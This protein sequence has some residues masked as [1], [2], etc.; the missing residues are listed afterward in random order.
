MSCVMD[1]LKIVF[2]ALIGLQALTT[3]AGENPP[4]ATPLGTGDIVES[5]NGKAKCYVEYSSGDERSSVKITFLDG[6]TKKIWNCVR[7]V[8][9]SWAPNSEYLAIDDY[10]LRI[11]TAVVV[12]KID[13]ERRSA[14]LIYQTPYSNSVFDRYFFGRWEN[15]GN[16]IVIS[17][18]PDGKKGMQE[19]RAVRLNNLMPIAQTIYP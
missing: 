5:P 14:D 9:V 6:T 11:A 12:F 19:W 10:L 18:I 16:G 8:G 2:V 1:H 17:V 4:V 7:S 13:Y 3:G 15:N